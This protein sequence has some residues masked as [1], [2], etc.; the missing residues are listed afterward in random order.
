VIMDRNISLNKFEDFGVKPV[1]SPQKIVE[2][3]QRA[4]GVDVPDAVAGYI[5]SIVDAT[6]NPKDYGFTKG[7]FLDCGVS[8]RASISLKSAVQAR[9]LMEG[10]TAATKEDVR[11]LAPDVLRHRLAINFEGQAESV[12]SDELIK[13]LLQKVK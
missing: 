6:R 3:Q 9:A 2:L 7:R 8:S 11:A 13:E 1:L 4:R 12:S 10:R 5:V